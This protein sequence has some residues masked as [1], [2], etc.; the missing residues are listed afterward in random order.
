MTAMRP[1]TMRSARDAT[2]NWTDDDDDDAGGQTQQS[3]THACY[4][5]ESYQE[6]VQREHGL[7]G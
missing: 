6:R 3:V 2:S 1:R 7:M 5:V 4:K